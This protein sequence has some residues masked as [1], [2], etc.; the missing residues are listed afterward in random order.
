VI[1]GKISMPT[2]ECASLSNQESAD[3]AEYDRLLDAVRMAVAPAPE[4]STSNQPAQVANDNQLAGGFIPFP[5]GWYG[6]G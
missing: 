6:V 5:E 3:E 1:L 2:Q 4:K